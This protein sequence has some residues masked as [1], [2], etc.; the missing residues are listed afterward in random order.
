MET[1]APISSLSR[2]VLVQAVNSDPPSASSLSTS[3]SSLLYLQFRTPAQNLRRELM[4]SSAHCC[5][6]HQLEL[7]NIPGLGLFSVKMEKI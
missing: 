1:E 7:D 3:R 2:Y 6:S 4:N 5:L